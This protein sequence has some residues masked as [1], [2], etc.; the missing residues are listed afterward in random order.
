MKR[1]LTKVLKQLPREEAM[2]TMVLSDLTSDLPFTKLIALPN[3][4]R[5]DVN[6]AVS[7]DPQLK[8]VGMGVGGWFGVGVWG[9]C[10]CV[11]GI[12]WVCGGMCVG[13]CGGMC[14]GCGCDALFPAVSALITSVTP[15]GSDALS[16]AV[17][18]LITSVTSPGSGALSPAVS[19]LITSV[20]SPG[21]QGVMPCLL[22]S[23]L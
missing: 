16:P 15:P 8:Q 10:V 20:T 21:L 17:S 14:V 19:A 12:V 6:T 4:C 18:A 9:D 23:V 5:Q 22:L 1:T 11:G 3:L 2:V 7:D 13:V